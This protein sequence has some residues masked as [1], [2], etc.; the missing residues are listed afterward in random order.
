VQVTLE[1]MGGNIATDSTAPVTLAIGNHAGGGTLM[2][3]LTVNAS[4]GV[5]T[6][7][8]VHLDTIGA[9][10]TL[11]A[12]APGYAGATSSAFDV[13]PASADMSTSSVQVPAS[14]VAADGASTAT[15][16]VHVLD[17]YGN[18]INTQ[19][20]TLDVSG[21]S[22]SLSPT[23]ATSGTDG[24]ATF[25][26]SSTRA[27]TKT[28]TAHVDGLSL[29]AQVV[30]DGAAPSMLH[31]TFTASVSA[32]T[33]DGTSTTT[34]TLTAIDANGNPVTGQTVTLSAT[35]SGNTLTP[36]TGPTNAAG[37]FVATLAS[38]TAEAKTITADIGAIAPTTMVTF[39]PG[40]PSGDTSTLTATPHTLPADGVTTTQLVA[41]VRD[42]HSNTVPNVAVTLAVS[43]SGYTLKP[44]ATGTT[45]ASG[46]VRANLSSTQVET[47]T[48]TATTSSLASFE[49]QVTFVQGPHLGFLTQPGNV[50]EGAPL[51]VVAG[52]IDGTGQPVT[53]AQVQVTLQ[54]GT[55]PGA[56]VLF[57]TNT[58]ASAGG[59]ATFGALS[60]DRAG[61]GYTLVATAA[62]WAPATSATFNV[63]AAPWRPTVAIGGGG[64]DALAQSTTGTLV[65]AQSAGGLYRSS[66][67]GAT[68]REVYRRTSSGRSTSVVG[69]S[70][71]DGGLFVAGIDQGVHVSHDGG[72]TWWVP[73]CFPAGQQGLSVAFDPG[74]A[75]VFY[76]AVPA[77]VYR[78][79]DGG[80][81]CALWSALTSVA[82]VVVNPRS[83]SELY[84]LQTGQ[85]VTLTHTI[86]GG[87]SFTAAT[88]VPG[89]EWLLFDPASVQGV[90]AA[91]TSG[92]YKSTD[93]GSTYG[94]VSTLAAATIAADQAGAHLY[95]TPSSTRDNSYFVST[96]H[97][98]TWSQ[99]AI[100]IDQQV[101]VQFLVTPNGVVYAA[102]SNGNAVSFGGLYMSTDWGTTWT[103]R[104][105][106][107]AA[108]VT[109]LATAAGGLLYASTYSGLY[110]SADAAGTWQYV[111]AATRRLAFAVAILGGGTDVLDA[112]FN[113]YPSSDSGGTFD[114]TVVNV[115]DASNLI[116][117]TGDPGTVYATTNTVFKTTNGG[118]SWQ[119]LSVMPNADCS[120]AID[121]QNP[122]HLLVAASSTLYESNT[123]G[124]GFTV[125]STF[126]GSYL[127]GMV[128]DPSNSQYVY[129]WPAPTLLRSTDGGTT[130][131]PVTPPLD[132]TALAFDAQA[133]TVY[134]ATIAPM[135]VYRSTDS[136]ATW[137]LA[138]TGLT[139]D[140]IK[141]LAT[142]PQA[143]GVVY[144]G[145][146]LHGVYKTTTGGL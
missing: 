119:A 77:G 66:D 8:D 59:V 102:A 33:A 75:S 86:D 18:P 28:L 137:S 94:K 32:L 110:R 73:P 30:F 124:A 126:T 45:D 61:T 88:S 81:T 51:V 122:Q 31:S 113:I 25:T 139:S 67:G 85:T 56:A 108:Y 35:G 16:Q 65:A 144:A 23:T 118:T 98:M 29:T 138:A 80:T 90:Y 141:V 71:I 100:A 79:T 34:L 132:V 47:K 116:V 11:V 95:A 146:A 13:T 84:L 57:G 49:T 121:H 60:M 26:L 145:T 142:D 36:T 6:F 92:I 27:E 12:T 64:V 106:G 39:T 63:T 74:N 5:A 1:A 15:I 69:A 87:A 43:G 78:T 22:N 41:T 133:G 21:T 91:A 127:V 37:V 125:R 107:L 4:A 17:A 114:T 128:L 76:V 104:S 44:G 20:V 42:A 53:T 24:V 135:A 70:P 96:D 89:M 120:L 48:V 38:T 54:I 9:G 130:F 68:W 52:I 3:T 7:T 62:G 101:M 46:V 82:Q 115:T 40:A 50:A 112:S 134:A 109:G 55:N 14:P 83:A 111:S 97:G 105:S 117:D 93:A 143:P 136:G 99:Q 19:S 58:L 103:D 140:P 129:V 2:G 123:G 72:Q 131:Q 10:Y